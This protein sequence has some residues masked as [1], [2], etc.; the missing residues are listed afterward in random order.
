MNDNNKLK[1]WIK[2]NKFKWV[3]IVGITGLL[4]GIGASFLLGS[5]LKQGF[6]MGSIYCVILI[7]VDRT[8][9]ENY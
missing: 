6:M 4:L 2:E 9:G 5:D 1:S 7:S 8:S 3:S